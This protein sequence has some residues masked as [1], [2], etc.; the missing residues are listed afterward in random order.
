MHPAIT[1]ACDFVFP[2]PGT[3]RY[4]YTI[5]NKYFCEC[6]W[7]KIHNSEFFFHKTGKRFVSCGGMLHFCDLRLVSTEPRGPKIS[8]FFIYTIHLIITFVLLGLFIA[9]LGWWN[10]VESE[11]ES[12]TFIVRIFCCWV[13]CSLPLK[14][15][16]FLL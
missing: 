7:I 2:S 8:S 14:L 1:A 16:P 4:G 12:D 3:Y 10:C 15:I 9:R 6:K 13:G 5:L 11:G